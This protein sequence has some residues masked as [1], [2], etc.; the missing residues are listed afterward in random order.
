MHGQARVGGLGAEAQVCDAEAG[1]LAQC[2]LQGL[3]ELLRIG[4][5]RGVPARAEGGPPVR[6][7]VPRP[8]PVRPLAAP[9]KHADGRLQHPRRRAALVLRGRRP[10]AGIEAAVVPRA[11]PGDL[12]LELPREEQRQG[13]DRLGEDGAVRAERPQPHRQR[14][15][16]RQ[17]SGPPASG[18][19][20]PRRGAC[21][22]RWPRPGRH[23]RQ[24]VER[25]LLR[26]A[27]SRRPDSPGPAASSLRQ[28]HPTRLPALGPQN[29]PVRVDQRGQV[30][31]RER[32]SGGVQE[33][34]NLVSRL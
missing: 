12:Q 11:S 26:L 32:P 16:K 3:P 28:D 30:L 1:V 20:H 29:A 5:S 27:P 7:G 19:P 9:L 4:Q 25:R 6:V 21:R 13:G 17:S 24:A 31:H 2:G 23:H 33:L 10:R 18:G 14:P 8:P 34:Q 22:R 15:H